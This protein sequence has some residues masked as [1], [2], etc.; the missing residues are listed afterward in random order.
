MAITFV[1]FADER[2]DRPHIRRRALFAFRALSAYDPDILK[3]VA[4]RARKRAKDV[5]ASVAHAALHVSDLLVKVYF[6]STS[7]RERRRLTTD[8]QDYFRKS[9]IASCSMSLCVLAG[10]LT[11]EVRAR[12]TSS[13]PFC[14]PSRPMSEPRV[15]P[16]SSSS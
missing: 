6:L 3:T 5:D 13:F 14:G 10:S 2:V 7:D 16:V 15:P 9:G 12:T 11:A 4:E 8:S 1:L